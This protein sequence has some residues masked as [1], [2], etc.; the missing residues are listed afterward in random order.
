MPDKTILKLETMYD[1][2]PIDADTVELLLKFVYTGN[3]SVPSNKV[4]PLLALSNYLGLERL[5]DICCSIIVKN[6]D[7]GNCLDLLEWS[8]LHQNSSCWQDV[9]QASLTFIASN[10]EKVLT[11]TQGNPSAISQLNIISVKD[12]ILSRDLPLETKFEF[13]MRWALPKYNVYSIF[14]LLGLSTKQT[15]SDKEESNCWVSVHMICMS[16]LASKFEPLSTHS[17]FVNLSLQELKELVTNDALVVCH[18]DVVVKS[19]LRWLS[20]NKGASLDEIIPLVRWAYVSTPTIWSC[21]CNPL[22]VG[23]NRLKDRLTEAIMYQCLPSDKKSS[24]TTTSKRA[25]YHNLPDVQPQ[26]FARDLLGMFQSLSKLEKEPS[27]LSQIASTKDFFV[28]VPEE[29]KSSSPPK[30]EFAFGT[31]H[32]ISDIKEENKQRKD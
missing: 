19:M 31:I 12:I 29:S 32:E 18:E 4:T 9:R 14:D 20:Y 10:C 21:A 1:N 11:K 5:C 25:S 3:V 24:V 26:D 22:L 16:Y 2:Q 8:T 15:S 23:N 28:F 27:A 30:E 13:F 17:Q 6:V 7:E